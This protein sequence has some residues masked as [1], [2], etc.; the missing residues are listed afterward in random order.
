MKT[1]VIYARYSSDSQSEQSIEGQ[2]RVCQEY[3]K[4][5]D[6]LILNTYIDRAMT[7]T[8]D[9]RPEFQQMLKDSNKREWNFVLVYKLDRFSRNKYEMAMHKKTLKDNGVK[10]VSAMEYIPDTPEAIIIESMLEGYAEYYSAELSQ[11]IKRGMFETRQKGFYQGGG[12]PYGYKI[13]GRKIEIDEEKAEIVKYIFNQYAS[14]IY[15]SQIIKDLTQKGILRKGKS[16]ATNTI[17]GILKNEK[18]LG[19]YKHENEVIDNM[20]PKIIDN[21]VFEKVRAK[22]RK[23]AYGKRS[24][25]TIYLL[26]N[27]LVCGYCGHPISAETGTSKQGKKINYYK[28]SGRKRLQNNCVKTTIR[29]DTLETFVLS[30]IILELQ[31]PSVMKLLIDNLMAMQKNLAEN[32]TMLKMLIKEHKQTQTSLDNVMS[33]IEQGIINKTT[34]KRMKELEENLERLERNILIEKSKCSIKI[35]RQTLEQ[36][37][38]EALQQEPL[39]LINDLVKEIKMYNDKMEITFNSPLRNNPSDKDSSFFIT[40]KEL[41]II[42]QNT[43]PR[44]E[45][46]K[47]E[48]YV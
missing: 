7:G 39:I 41:P 1:A 32:N 46:I 9:N 25:K 27:K 19:I 38:V 40:L 24:V 16:F 21:E 18:Y 10:L 15:V 35:P 47:I 48:M 29:K 37:Y 34:N 22:S 17:Y 13:N 12:L 26:R 14:G 33:A 45:K 23:N 5:H 42:V 30:Q 20:Y 3:A 28:C 6:I 11:K 44:M 8:N 4:A 31:K 2:L 43:K 36:Y